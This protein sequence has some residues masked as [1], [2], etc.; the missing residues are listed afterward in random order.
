MR[1]AWT[2]GCCAPPGFAQIH[3]EARAGVLPRGLPRRTVL[4]GMVGMLAIEDRSEAI[5]R[6]LLDI[7]PVGYAA[8]RADPR[9]SSRRGKRVAS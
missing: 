4:T 7:V 8:E 5:T 1:T 9:H 2:L 6:D 3:V